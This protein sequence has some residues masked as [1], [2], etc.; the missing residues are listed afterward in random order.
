M[1]V[2]LTCLSNRE[3]DRRAVLI[4]NGPSLNQM[5][6][7]FLKN[8]ITI[9][10]NKIHLGFKHFGF[11]PKYYVAVN[12]LVIQQTQ[13]QINR[14]NCIKFISKRNKNIIKPSALTRFID[15]SNPP[16][17]FCKDI[18]LGVH[19]G[20][21]VTYAAIQIAYYLGIKQLVLIGLDHR[22]TYSGAPNETTIIE[23][24]DPN[25][26]SSNYFGHGQRWDNPDLAKSEESYRI[27]KEVFESDGREIIDCTVDGACQIFRKADYQQLF[28]LAPQ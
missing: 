21:T 16:H 24:D 26:F 1:N 14:L 19:E 23:G 4:A 15:T 12:D 25:H 13:D 10:L 18:S 9:G 5:D 8:E 22:Y 11:Y 28:S 7:S 6:L 17:R 3:I 2:G 27:A 20:W